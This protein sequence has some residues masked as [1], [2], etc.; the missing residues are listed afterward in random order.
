MSC[1]YSFVYLLL[2]NFII[3]L[4]VIV[5][6]Y[7]ALVPLIILTFLL[8]DCPATVYSVLAHWSGFIGRGHTR[9]GFMVRMTWY[10][11]CGSVFC[12]GACRLNHSIFCG[13]GGV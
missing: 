5:P 10:I 9:R 4:F 13:T 11:G 12:E 3:F 1:V 8:N 7:L 2:Y 6:C